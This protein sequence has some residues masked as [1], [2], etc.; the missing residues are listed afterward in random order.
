MQKNMWRMA[1][2]VCLGLAGP[3]WADSVIAD[4]LIVQGSACIGFDCVNGESF[5]A[6]ETLLL[7]GNNLLVTFDDTSSIGGF[8]VN[9]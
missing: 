7:K 3:V 5:S 2:A 8:P 1:A 9:D 6:D 4:D